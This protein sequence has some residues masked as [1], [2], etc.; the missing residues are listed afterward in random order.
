MRTVRTTVDT[1]GDAMQTLRLQRRLDRTQIARLT[2]I[3]RQTW[4]R[5]ETGQTIPQL[6]QVQQVANALDITFEI[7]PDHR[8]A[9]INNNLWRRP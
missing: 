1:L 5:W 9:T 6:P 3:K 4:H 8:Q 2:G 7:R